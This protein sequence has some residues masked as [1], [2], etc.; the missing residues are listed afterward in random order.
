[1]MK[2]ATRLLALFL[3]AA[4]LAQAPTATLAGKVTDQT[5]AVIPGATV[6]VTS[7]AGKQTTTTTGPEGGFQIDSLAPGT[8]NVAATAKGFASLAR[9]G[10]VL[11]T[12]HPSNVTL[13]LQI[14]TQEEKVH[15]E[16]AEG[17]PELD[18]SASSNAS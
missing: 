17:R 16:G 18:V 9:Q 15:V 13:T 7:A 5:G 10:V 4:A 6:T 2:R 12:D 11:A 8:Y 1:M 14:Q 3:Y